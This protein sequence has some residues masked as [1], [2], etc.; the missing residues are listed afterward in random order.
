MSDDRTDSGTGAKE[1]DAPLES[2]GGPSEDSTMQ[3]PPN[4]PASKDPVLVQLHP[5]FR[6]L[7]YLKRHSF[8]LVDTA[9]LAPERR[10]KLAGEICNVVRG[11]RVWRRC[12]WWP[13]E[14]AKRKRRGKGG[15][16]GVGGEGLRDGEVDGEQDEVDGSDGEV[17]GGESMER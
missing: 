11:E 13:G 15:D 14:W 16:D 10:N 1:L 12:V 6:S 9:A 5:R 2:N 4:Q 8:V 3:I 7:I 17:E